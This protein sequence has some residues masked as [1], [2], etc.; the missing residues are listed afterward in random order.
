MR[1]K[2]LTKS[3]PAIVGRN[4]S[5]PVRSKSAA[6]QLINGTA[7]QIPVLETSTGQHHLTF[8]NLGGDAHQPF[9][10]SIVKSTGNN[11]FPH[12]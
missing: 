10:Q 3:E 12:T 2:H 5:V 4:H 11:G 9:H 1:G 7:R 6:F 8:T